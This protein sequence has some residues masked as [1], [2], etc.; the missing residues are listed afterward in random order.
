[1]DILSFSLWFPNFQTKYRFYF[2]SGIIPQPFTAKFWKMFF[3][4]EKREALKENFESEEEID[5]VEK[6]K[7][8]Q[9]YFYKRPLSL[10]EMSI[11]STKVYENKVEI[12]IR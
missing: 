5:G 7:V 2:E 1:M 11:K 12:Q 6:A 9:S 4:K 8:E 10:C 3:N